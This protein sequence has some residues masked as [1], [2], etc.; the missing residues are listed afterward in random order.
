MLCIPDDKTVN[1]CGQS[2][3]ELLISNACL[4]TEELINANTFQD[5]E[6]LRGDGKVVLR[7]IL[8]RYLASCLDMSFKV[9]FALFH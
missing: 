4:A 7:L 8:F 3:E 6:N 5:S 2:A 9:L 1:L